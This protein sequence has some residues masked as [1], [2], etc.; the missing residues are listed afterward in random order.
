MRS[1]WLVYWLYDDR[2][3]CYAR[4]GCIGATKA[5]RLYIRLH[6]H[7]TRKRFPDFRYKVIFRGSQK[8]ALAIEAQLRPRPYIGWNIGIGGFANGRGLKGLPKS[9]EWRAAMSESAKRRYADLAER[10]RMSEAVKRGLK[11]VDRTG[12]NNPNFGKTTSE[13]AKQKMREKIAER[14]GV[15]GRNNPN[16]RH[17]HDV[18]SRR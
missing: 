15:S 2:C 14:G 8:I 6:Q 18:T 1:E 3:V 17:G 4:H 5:S 9:F 13:A 7:R 11:G 12:A 16:Y 10:E